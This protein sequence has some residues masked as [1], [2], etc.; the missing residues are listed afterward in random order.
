MNREHVSS[1]PSQWE[2]TSDFGFSFKQIIKVIPE[3]GNKNQSVPVRS[4]TSLPSAQKQ[5]QI[6]PYKRSYLTASCSLQS[7]GKNLK[8]SAHPGTF[9]QIKR[10]ELNLLWPDHV[11]GNV[12][13]LWQPIQ[14]SSELWGLPGRSAWLCGNTMGV[15]HFLVSIQKLEK[16]A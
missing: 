6:L 5:A 13:V 8:W 4:Q 3:S 7:Q 1:K 11:Q 15:K 2:Y 14:S 9:L 12:K 10:W 16:S